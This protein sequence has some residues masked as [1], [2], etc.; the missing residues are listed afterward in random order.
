MPPTQRFARLLVWSF[1]FV[2]C[3]GF[4]AATSR[5]EVGSPGKAAE[6]V[7][8]SF[9]KPVRPSVPDPAVSSPVQAEFWKAHAARIRNPIDAFVLAKL[10]E[11]GLPPAPLADRQTLVRRAYFDLLGLP[12]S[13]EQVAKFV[14]DSSVDAWPNLID[15]LLKSPHYGERWGRHW[16]DVARYADSGGYETDVYY[17]NAWRYRDYVVKSFNDDKPYDQFV[18]EQI[19]ADELWPD[20]LDLDAT[21]VMSADKVKH[22]EARIGTGFFA[23]GPMIHE[24]SMDAKKLQ[25][26]RLTDWVDTAGSAFLGLTLACA[27]CHDHKFD[28]LTQKDYFG[29]QAAF[30][31]SK[32]IELPIVNAME[33]TDFKQFYPRIIAVDEARK[34]CR[35]FEKKLGGKAPSDEEQK[36]Q[37]QLL[38]A[39]ARAL[40]AVPEAAGSSP[41]T[42]YDGI[43]EIPTVT[44]LG[45]E[46]PEL[47]SP[48]Y[49]LSRGDLDRR[50]GKVDA[51][52]P[53]VVATSTG[54]P[55]VLP[56]PFGGRKA[57]ALWLTQPDH[58]LTSRVMVNRLWQWH[59][60]RGLVGT[61]N[62][63]GKMGEA[64]THPELL[65]WLATEFVARGWSVK[66]MHRL[67]MLSSTYQMTSSFAADRSLA[68]DPDNRLLWRMNR[69]RLEGEALWD[70]LHAVG[71]TL[72]LKVGGRPVVPPLPE[73]ELSAMRDRWQWTVSADPQDH[74]R[75]ALYVL[76][77][78][79]FRFPVLDVF[80]A[81]VNS[82]SCP[83]RDVTTVA[84][85][86]L[87]FMNN[88]TALRQAQE[89]AGRIVKDAGDE[90]AIWVDQAW[91]IALGRP[92]SE[93]ERQKARNFIRKLAAD[94][95]ASE[96]PSGLESPPPALAALPP[97]RAAALVKL[98]LTV[99]NL[100]EFAYID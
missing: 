80:D 63:F 75:R 44:V 69:R 51:A 31:G 74:C 68:V 76:V 20:N 35:L 6:E 48:V 86:A 81:P 38:E 9:R 16:L 58:P 60:G 4:W 65:D 92:P 55:T 14:G 84:P 47:I 39:L 99:M 24:S 52:L 28:P 100:N 50:Q 27:R 40:L 37:R 22:L 91:S 21:Y 49:L 1:C 98:C 2:T 89:F 11:Q 33:Q 77:R 7:F 5:A 90:P 57:L 46:R 70:A 26:E 82:V 64:P 88:R 67:I 62:D 8:W 18:Q 3:S 79:N 83:V 32:E 96:E 29:L 71:G 30:A 36:Q 53:A 78:R 73:D 43:M 94:D 85:Q 45:H 17:R 41:G 72:N 93:A 59:F 97:A 23:L 19:A 61:P 54:T 87:W 13:P 15:E 25:Y 10:A 34:A 56:G 95:A 42:R 12:P 66:Q